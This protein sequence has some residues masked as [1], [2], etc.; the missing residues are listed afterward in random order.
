MTKN[1]ELTD[2]EYRKL[3]VLLSLGITIASGNGDFDDTVDYIYS[4]AE[5]FNC[6]DIFA[7]KMGKTYPTHKH[8]ELVQP[9]IDSYH[10]EIVL[11]Y[12]L[13]GRLAARDFETSNAHDA[14]QQT[15]SEEKEMEMDKIKERY[16]T[17]LMENGVKNLFIRS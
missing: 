8:D 3:T 16:S 5:K 2:E 13:A 10:D 6:N 11:V 1:I 14:I 15:T 12:H 7:K 4:C 9:L 17:E